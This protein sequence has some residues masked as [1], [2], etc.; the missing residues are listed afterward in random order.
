MKNSIDKSF[1]EFCRCLYQAK[2]IVRELERRSIFIIQDQQEF[3]QVNLYY[4]KF[5]RLCKILLI[6]LSQFG[7]S[8]KIKKERI[9][10]FRLEVLQE[11]RMATHIKQKL[12]LFYCYTHYS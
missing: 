9:D 8:G 3:Q 2:A 12:H 6:I 1:I 5:T 10:S 7:S 4:L 11:Y